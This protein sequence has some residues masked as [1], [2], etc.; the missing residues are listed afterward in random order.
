MKEITIG[1]F[2]FQ[3]C[4]VFPSD[5]SKFLIQ[6]ISRFNKS[7]W[8]ELEGCWKKPEVCHVCCGKSKIG[9]I[10]VD[11]D[12][13]NNPTLLADAWNLSKI[14]GVGKQ[15]VIVIDPPWQINWRQRQLLSYEMRDCLKV[16]GT[17]IQNSPWSP[18][19]VGMEILAIWKVSSH[20]NN[21]TDLRDFWILRRVA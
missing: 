7:Y 15:N 21:Y 2:K 20:F 14:L 18:W 11:I 1:K 5:V 8:D 16:G 12:P 10:R 13:E 3:K 4:W 9:E 19:C 17:L 6:M